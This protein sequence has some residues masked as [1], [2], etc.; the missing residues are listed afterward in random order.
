MRIFI[1]PGH[2]GHDPGCIGPTGLREAPL[3]LEVAKRLERLLTAS[4]HQVKLSREEDIFVPLEEQARMANTWGADIFLCL[5]FNAATSPQAKGFEV[6]TSPGQTNADAW[7][8]SIYEGLQRDGKLGPG[9]M[10]MT[11]GDADKEARFAVLRLTKMPAVLIEYGFLSN[12]D[13]EARFRRLSAVDDLAFATLDGLTHH[14]AAVQ[15]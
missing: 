3:A 4:W 13:T 7:A 1:A 12:P 6:W 8:Q 11:D 14:L 15:A 5:H 9:R 10:D 2:G